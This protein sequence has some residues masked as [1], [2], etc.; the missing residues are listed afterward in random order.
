MKSSLKILGAKTKYGRLHDA[1]LADIAAGV[2]PPG[3]RLPPIQ[4]IMASRD[5]SQAT[6]MRAI[7]MLARKGVLER[8]PGVGVFVTK[9]AQGGAGELSMQLGWASRIVY[10]ALEPKPLV[11]EAD[12]GLSAKTPDILQV[13]PLRCADYVRHGAIIPLDPFLEK[14]AAFAESLDRRGT[15]NYQHPGGIYALPVYFA[16]FV[17]HFNLDA[18]A[19]AGIE[20]PSAG[21]TWDALKEIA[22][23]FHKRGVAR[24][25]DW[26][27]HVAFLLPFIFA[28]GLS[29][30]SAESG[31]FVLNTPEMR[32][33]F[34]KL[35]ELARLCG[36]P[37]KL[38]NKQP[39]ELF[40]QGASPILLWG[41]IDEAASLP[42]RHS[43]APLPGG[44]QAPTVILSEGL[45]IS[46][47]CECPELAWSVIK[48]FTGPKASEI[49]VS[50]RIMFP[51]RSQGVLDFLTQHGDG[52]LSAYRSL[53]NAVSEHIPF[54]SENTWILDKAMH[55][56][57]RK[58]D[59]VEHRLASAQA[60]LDAVLA[61]AS[62]PLLD[63]MLHA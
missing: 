19:A 1:L 12:A 7:E 3:S 57:W 24:P 41:A 4:E 55:G 36:S 13:T 59:D 45:A 28:E 34:G 62:M 32:Q 6:A 43:V 51:A 54:G 18:F 16:P 35:K 17:T 20:P 61:A 58:E 56:W 27:N 21:L 5:I 39:L 63:A 44:E 60:I 9:A 50:K 25:L 30:Y 10:Q 38:S 37:S 47:Q 40:K 14:D 49:L 42:F 46:S 23:G 53:D 33:V 2:Y 52:Y 22:R 8:R 31:R 11:V 29:P 48:R 26:C 15:N